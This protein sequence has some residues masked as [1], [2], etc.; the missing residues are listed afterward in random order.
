MGFGD[1]TLMSVEHSPDVVASGSLD[2][3]PGE[4]AEAVTTTRERSWEGDGEV[5]RGLH[6]LT[7]VQIVHDVLVVDV[8][9]FYGDGYSLP[10]VIRGEKD[11]AGWT[12]VLT[13]LDYEQRR[14]TYLVEG[15]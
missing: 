14:A 13:G 15:N 8:A 7:S 12:A 5:P 1:R 3:F 11:G 4:L 2:D 10:T 6:A 9:E